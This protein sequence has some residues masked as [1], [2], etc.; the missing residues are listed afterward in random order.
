MAGICCGDGQFPLKLGSAINASRIDRVAFDI[1]TVF[2]SIEH[3]IGRKVDDGGAVACSRRRDRAGAVPVEGKR[4]IWL[5]FGLVDRGIGGGIDDDV[6]TKVRQRF[7]NRGRAQQI[8]IRPLR[9]AEN[10]I[11][12]PRC[13][14]PQRPGNLALARQ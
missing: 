8:D 13:G 10:D 14:F 7:R 3:I 4:L 9:T 6:G 5:G 11:V 12:V 2:G 1:S